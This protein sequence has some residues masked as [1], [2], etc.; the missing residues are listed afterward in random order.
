MEKYTVYRHKNKTNGMIYIGMTVQ[1]VKKRWKNGNGYHSKLFSEAIKEFGWDG[2][3]HE[4]IASDLSKKDATEME[5]L[6]IKSH[7]SNNPQYGY[8]CTIGGDGGGM[9]N[10]KQTPVAKAKISATMKTLTFSDEH[11]KHISE[12]KSGINHQFAKK[13]YQYTKEHV[14]VREWDYMSQA[15]KELNIS[16]GNIGEVCNGHRKTAGGYVWT[17]ERM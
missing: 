17:Y 2:F 4:I 14:F 11:K 7:K 5:K 8:N 16:K 9:L 6:L 12:A 13:V 10:K 1:A 3:T 15:A